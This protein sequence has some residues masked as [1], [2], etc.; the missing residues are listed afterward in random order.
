MNTI[1]HLLT[2]YFYYRSGGLYKH[3]THPWVLKTCNNYKYEDQYL[4]INIPDIDPNV[5]PYYGLFSMSA[6]DFLQVYQ[7]KGKLV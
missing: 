2:I 3:T 7:K 4:S 5:L 6:G 1:L